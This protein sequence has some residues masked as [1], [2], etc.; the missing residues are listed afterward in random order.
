MLGPT[1]SCLE[2]K[3]GL[4]FLS[5]GSSFRMEKLSEGSVMAS[6]LMIYVVSTV[7]ILSVCFLACEVLAA[8]FMG[9]K[10][11]PPPFLSLDS[12]S[13][14]RRRS[15]RG[16]N[17][18]SGGSGLLDIIGQTMVT[19]SNGSFFAKDIVA[20][21]EQIQPFHRVHGNLMDT[22]GPSRTENLLSKSS[23]FTSTASNDIFG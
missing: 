11:S 21:R 23:F 9:P 16:I 18:N 19:I 17:F 5:M 1:T 4:T 3:P 6:T 13:A 7:L 22:M 2:A 20:L 10:R 14:V 12:A 15:F 8:M